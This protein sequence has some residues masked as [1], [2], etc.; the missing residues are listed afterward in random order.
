MTMTPAWL[1]YLCGVLMLAVATYSIGLLLI[2]L[3]TGRKAGR[4]VE[5]SHVF[6]G[7]S[8]AGMFVADWAFGPSGFWELVFVAFLT[9][10]VVRAV[11][12]VVTYGPHVPHTAVHALMSFAMLLMYWFPMGSGTGSMSMSASSA[13]TGRVDPGLAFV[14]AFLLL[15]SAIFTLASPT[16]GRS[17]YGSHNA[18]V[19]AGASASGGLV[20]AEGGLT[21][22][23]ATHSSSSD[24]FVLAISRPVFVD[25]THVAMSVAMGFLLILMI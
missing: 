17:V 13:A 14:V 19:A 11:R 24:N 6:M 5:L 12:S 20:Q 9:W 16:K 1:Y 4:D 10:F 15:G 21:V 18:L 25:L 7:V 3:R 2:S 22:H 23:P 8:M